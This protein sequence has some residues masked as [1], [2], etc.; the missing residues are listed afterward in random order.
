[1]PYLALEGQD[2]THSLINPEHEVQHFDSATDYVSLTML[3]VFIIMAIVFIRK[4]L[5]VCLASLTIATLAACH[6]F[7]SLAIP[8][9]IHYEWSEGN[10]LKATSVAA[11]YREKVDK[12][13]SGYNYPRGIESE[14]DL[15]QY[16][17]EQLEFLSLAHGIK[18]SLIHDN[19][20]RLNRLL[21]LWPN[22]EPR[23]RERALWSNVNVA[24]ANYFTD[25]EA[26]EQAYSFAKTAN[27]MDNNSVSLEVLNQTTLN[28]VFLAANEH[29]FSEAINLLNRLSSKWES[30]GQTLALSILANNLSS[31]VLDT[32]KA[33]FNPDPLIDAADKFESFRQRQKTITPGQRNLYVDCNMADVLTFIAK[34]RLEEGNADKAAS[35]TF[36]A[37]DLIE[38]SPI[39]THYLINSLQMQASQSIE[40]GDFKIAAD[41]LKKA[42]QRRND[43]VLDC[44]ISFVE[45]NHAMHLLT[46][47]ELNRSYQLLKEAEARCP[48]MPDLMDMKAKLSFAYAQQQLRLG[49]FDT[50]QAYIAQIPHDAQVAK[51]ADNLART[52]PHLKQFLHG[53]DLSVGLESLPSIDG[54]LCRMDDEQCGTIEL[55][56]NGTRVGAAIPHSGELQFFDRGV[57]DFT[58]FKSHRNNS[59]FNE[60]T[61]FKGES[62]TGRLDN[63]RDQLPDWEFE[64]YDGNITSEKQLSGKISLGFAAALNNSS[65]DYFSKPDMLIEV[66]K[67]GDRIGITETQLNTYRPKY[68]TVANIHYRYGD[69]ITLK[70]WDDDTLSIGTLVLK[71]SYEYMGKLKL[72]SFPDTG[73]YA[74]NKNI[75]LHLAVSETNL[76]E[77]M[78][79]DPHVLSKEANPFE[80]ELSY[81][82]EEMTSYLLA[83]YDAEA[84]STWTEIGGSFLIAEG[85][86]LPF[87]NATLIQKL[88]LTFIGQEAAYEKLTEQTNPKNHLTFGAK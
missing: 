7:F 23:G 39:N 59:Y 74:A 42:A 79:T 87:R 48:S 38:N 58:V 9:Y 63:D 47:D 21:G 24:L 35:L 43:R 46:N 53:Y 16:R 17:I 40:K 25:L 71:E 4:R 84:H 76:P 45:G 20:M 34:Y 83:S 3:I 86:M 61:H 82:N 80:S 33:G 27:E 70:F 68:S 62:A 77:G 11:S 65:Q 75:G 41:Y 66:F 72:D 69:N 54:L 56:R 51:A 2:F 18:Q 37:E 19:S 1:M 44:D 55:Y 57:R 30:E 85:I 64:I 22:V 28:Q 29:K 14:I 13:K 78:S 67:N 52:I 88:I 32:Q 31:V 15:I 10:Y 6:V 73:F 49:D 8:A 12:L 26:Y 60:V 81:Q 50:S 36:R 5:S